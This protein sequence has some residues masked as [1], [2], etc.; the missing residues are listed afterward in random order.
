MTGMAHL[1]RSFP[2]PR[3]PELAPGDRGVLSA[4]DAAGDSL[5]SMAARLPDGGLTMALAPG[6]DHRAELSHPLSSRF[7]AQSIAFARCDRS[8]GEWRVLRDH[9]ERLRDTL[10][11][12]RSAAFIEAMIAVAAAVA[13]AD[14]LRRHQMGTAPDDRGHYVLYPPESVVEHRL[15]RLFAALRS[16]RAGSR[17]FEGILALVWLTHCHPFVDG[18]GRTSRI[19][20][21][22]LLQRDRDR[23]A[24]YLPLY[25]FARLSRRGYI[26]RVRQAELFGDW[27]ALYDFV[28][29]AT[30]IWTATLVHHS[31][32]SLAER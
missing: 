7:P 21:N 29:A 27:S 24:Y 5:A 30:R 10:D 4:I 11:G 28:G 8:A 14:G 12:D 31:S 15:H 20:F 3:W 16:R 6:D 25:E 23:P 19:L 18:N 32:M 9:H 2:M 17:S 26:L 22:M 1:R 13:G